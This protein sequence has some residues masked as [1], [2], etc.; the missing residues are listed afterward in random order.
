MTAWVRERTPSLRR[1]TVTWAFTVGFADA[2]L[3]GDLLV[4]VALHHQRQ[5]APLL[6]RELG[7]ALGEG[8]AGSA[9]CGGARI[10]PSS[11]ARTVAAISS[12]EADLST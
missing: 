4:L 12:S 9:A 3:V 5:H 11:T 10:S 8:I 2:E 1:I 6:R 7:G